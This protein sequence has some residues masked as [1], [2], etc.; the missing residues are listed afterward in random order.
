MLS[1]KL[2]KSR[3]RNVGQH[4][5]YLSRDDD[6]VAQAIV[7][8]KVWAKCGGKKAKLFAI[9]LVIPDNIL[10]WLLFSKLDGLTMTKL[11]N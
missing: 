2:V 1:T 8:E 5:L 11:Y 6:Q 3:W 7:T 10:N 4:H 9:S